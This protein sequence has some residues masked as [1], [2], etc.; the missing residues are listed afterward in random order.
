EVRIQLQPNK[1][2]RRHRLRR[3]F[4][5]LFSSLRRQ[6]W[7][8]GEVEHGSDETVLFVICLLFVFVPLFV[9]NICVTRTLCIRMS[10]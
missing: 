8:D 10:T 6:K 7:G 1:R 3:R 4:S 5:P 9:V 2:D